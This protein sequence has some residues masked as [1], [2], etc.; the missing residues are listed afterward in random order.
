M[1]SMPAMPDS[2]SSQRADMQGRRWGILTENYG[3]NDSLIIEWMAAQVGAGAAALGEP[4]LSANTLLLAATQSSTPGLYGIGAP[5]LAHPGG[6]EGLPAALE[7][8]G[9]WTRM[10]YVHKMV[11]GVGDWVLKLDVVA[12]SLVVQN[13]WPW[14]V[15]T[16]TDPHDAS[17]LL[18]LR[19]LTWRK[20]GMNGDECAW[21]WDVWELGPVLRYYIM[22][23]T[24]NGDMMVSNLHIQTPT[25]DYA[26]AEGLT[27]DAYPYRYANGTPFIPFVFYADMDDGQLWH[28]NSRRGATR[29]ALNSITA[30]TYMLRAMYASALP[31]AVAINLMQP[32][33]AVQGVGDYGPAGSGTVQSMPTVPGMMLFTHTTSPEA[34]GSIHQLSNGANL[35]ALQQSVVIYGSGQ[36]ARMGLSADDMQQASASNPQSAGALLLTRTAKRER[37][38]QVAPFF[39]RRD[40]EATAKAAALLRLAGLGDYPEAGWSIE[41]RIIPLGPDEA[42]AGREQD[43]WDLAHHTCSIVDVYLRD[44]PGLTRAEAVAALKR[45]KEE[46]DMLGE[47]EPTAEESAEKMDPETPTET[48]T[49]D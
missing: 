44:H 22:R 6:H 46:N 47:D 36:F 30:N 17:R 39:R 28:S 49:E 27:G 18:E 7:G 15:W 25:G 43:D 1:L 19:Y 21:H 24:T 9:Y 14:M 35:Q 4:D 33:A 26:P 32:S 29:G 10:Q 2:E 23:P 8:A 42:K 45:N 40:L 3:V 34:Q 48:E 12:G 38:Q 31:P 13:A 5:M 37:A 16:R 20:T 41:Y 11:A